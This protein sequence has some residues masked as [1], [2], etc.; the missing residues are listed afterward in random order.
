M[1]FLF[2]R[3]TLGYT[4]EYDLFLGKAVLHLLALESVRDASNVMEKYISLCESEGRYKETPL[5]NMLKLLIETVHR[6]KKARPLF[7]LL[8][9]MYQK[10]ILRDPV[11]QS[12]MSRI[13]FN[14][15]EIPIRKAGGVLGMLESLMGGGGK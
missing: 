1:S 2:S 7:E 11:L 4:G 3:A 5:I 12:C 8:Q 6:G 10:S 15:F 13:G 14:Y 9:K